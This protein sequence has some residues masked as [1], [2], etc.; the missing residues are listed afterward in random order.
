MKRYLF[1]WE[2]GDGIG[3]LAR[4]QQLIELLL[5]RGDDVMFASKNLHSAKR[6]YG[7]L[8]V[9]LVQAP[10]HHRKPA[11]MIKPNSYVDVLLNQGFN[12]LEAVKV[13]VRAWLQLLEQWQPAIVVADHSPTV[14]L[15][16]RIYRGASCVV[17]GN[18][19]CIPPM[20]HPFPP[21]YA[22]ILSTRESL[23]QKEREL[24]Q[25]VINPAL[26][27][28]GGQALEQCQQLFSSHKHWL[29]GLPSLDHYSGGRAHSYLGT[30]PSMDGAP[31]S[32]PDVQGPRVFVYIKAHP[33]VP[34]FLKVLQAL[35]WPVL[36]YTANW[37]DELKQAAQAPNIRLSAQPLDLQSV[38][39]SCQ[40]AVT[41]G[42]LNSV[43]ELLYHGTPQLLIPHHIEQMM[44]SRAAENTGACMILAATQRDPQHF[45]IAL[46]KLAD[47][48]GSYKLA[49]HK[50]AS[51][52]RK[53]EMTVQADD[54]L[55]LLD[56]SI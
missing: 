45:R 43:I 13:R 25:S 12:D 11:D 24:L 26:R 9:K 47:P 30:S 8:P 18:G 55:Q 56:S 42:G 22:Q 3:H 52:H 39:G 37:S 29:F 20:G 4:Y 1:T 53:S 6:V 31:V 49:A 19:F 46:E 36:I 15:A 44:F 54:L 16:L 17:G 27:D 23:M 38:G 28:L 32:W 41:N 35:R 51:D 40:L 21:F 2:C 50:F 34:Q 5:D 7:Q 33:T 14:L 10:R 48:Q